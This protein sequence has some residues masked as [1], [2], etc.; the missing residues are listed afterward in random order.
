MKYICC[1]CG[2]EI[3]HGQVDPLHLLLKSLGSSGDVSEGTQDLFC[4]ANCLSERISTGI[5]FLFFSEDG[6]L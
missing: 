4:H 5:P 1:F 3:R 2:D 6:G